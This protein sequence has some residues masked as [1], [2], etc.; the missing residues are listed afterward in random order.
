M[1]KIMSKLC[2]LVKLCH[3]NSSGPVYGNGVHRHVLFYKLTD[4]M[5]TFLSRY[6]L[7]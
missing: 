7:Y 5:V 6:S 3:I 4:I 1:P 2:E